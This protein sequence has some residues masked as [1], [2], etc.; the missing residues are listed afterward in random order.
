MDAIGY[1]TMQVEGLP[2]AVRRRVDDLTDDQ[3]TWRPTPTANHVA[4]IAWHCLR[5][6]DMQLGRVR[7]AGPDGEVWQVGGFT[8]RTGY[9]PRGLGM[10]GMGIGTGYTLQMVDAVPYSKD[11]I[12][13]Y[14][15]A[16]AEAYKEHLA[17]MTDS[18]LDG[19]SLVPGDAPAARAVDSIEVALRQFSQHMGECDF[20]RG[21]I[22]I[23]D[24]TRPADE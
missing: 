21:L 6:C 20:L 15:E 12:T 1:I 5:A 4:F 14:A 3:F 2:A 24:P 11:L 17:T 10:R 7:H 13:S 8:E 9:D 16:V 22:G 19:A 23:P 18:D